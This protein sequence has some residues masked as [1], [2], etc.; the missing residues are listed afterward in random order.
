MQALVRIDGSQRVEV[1]PR[2]VRFRFL[3]VD[4]RQ[5]QERQVPLPW[6]RWPDLAADRVSRPQA[7]TLDLRRRDVDVI[8]AGAVGP[9]LRAQEAVALGQDLEHALGLQRRGRTVE[10]ALFD[11]V[12]EVLF[13]EA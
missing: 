7:E 3:P 9:V 1:W 13:P 2:R 10:Q 11:A 8:R 6:L 12:D 4:R 5:P